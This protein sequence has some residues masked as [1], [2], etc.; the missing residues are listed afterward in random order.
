MR[1]HPV[2]G[3]AEKIMPAYM[4]DLKAIVNIDSGTYTKAGIDR[5]GAYLADRFS[6]L[7]FLYLVRQ[8]ARIRR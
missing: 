2:V 8:T 4:D 3:R 5:V 1:Q 7:R 6:D